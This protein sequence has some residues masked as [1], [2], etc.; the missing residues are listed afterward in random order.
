MARV[1]GCAIRLSGLGVM[2]EAWMGSQEI[3]RK[4]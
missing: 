4:L 2:L 1:S 3:R